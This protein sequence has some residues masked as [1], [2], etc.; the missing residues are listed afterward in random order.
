MARIRTTVRPDLGSAQG[1]GWAWSVVR[2]GDMER[3]AGEACTR[4]L[5]IANLHIKD[6]HP[7]RRKRP[8]L[9]TVTRAGELLSGP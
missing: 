7:I 3:A 8:G 1:H 6:E 5:Y 2:V 9:K 4:G